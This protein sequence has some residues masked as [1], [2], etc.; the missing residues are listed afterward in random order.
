MSG[1]TNM[2]RRTFLK[3][4]VAI[5][6][7]LVI[8]ISI[9][10]TVK[11]GE[12]APEA[13][14]LPAAFIRIGSDNSVTIIINKSEMGQGVY[15]SLPM[16]VAEELEC[17][18]KMIRVE[19][20]PVAPVYNHTTFGVQATGGSTSIR[21]EW[22][23]LSKAGAA[24]RE[25]LVAAAAKRWR[26]E[27]SRCRAGNGAVTGPGGALLTYGE[28]AEEAARM[29]VPAKVTLK[30][31]RQYRVIGTPRHRLD[32]P[33]KVN[34]TAEFGIDVQV[35]GMLTAVVARSPVFGGRVAGLKADRA[36]SVPG[37][38]AVVQVPSGV[39]V[40]ATGFWPALKGRQLLEITWDEGKGAALSTPALRAE[41]AA[42]AARP[43]N[44]ARKDGD[45]KGVLTKATRRIDAEYEVPFLAHAPMEPLN[46]FVDLKADR[47]I[48]RVGTQ[49]Q[50]VDLHAAA[51]VAGLKPE[52]VELKTTYLGGGFG[53]RANPASDF[54]A[55]AVQVA[56][57][58]KKP[59][60]VI[61]T[62]GDD[63]KGGYYRPLWYDRISAG[64][65]AEG[66]LTAWGHTIVG[67]SII[68]GTPFE[69]AM[70][71][72]GVDVSS[73][74]GAS[75]L[76]YAV[77]NILVD[78]HTPKSMVPVLWWRSVGHSHTAFV[79]E[80]FM[81][82]VAHA[83]GKDPVE[84]RRS[85]LSGHPRHRG[86]LDLAA[87]KAGWGTPL[88]AG[89]A[90]G[91]AL[92][93]SFGSF[94]AQAAEVSV[95]GKGVVR[96]HRVVCAIDC[97]RIVNPD[98]IAAQMES[99]IAFG[100]SATLHGAITLKGGRVEQ[101]N[102]DTYPILRMNEMPKVEVHIVPSQDPPGGVGEP[103]VPPIAP[104]VANALFALTGIRVR[105]LP[106]TPDKVLQAMKKG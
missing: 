24:A 37:V 59:V 11:P 80:S 70:I 28:L 90:R 54:V 20:A 84:F 60:K 23:R 46:C 1:I 32:T 29:P 13:P 102:F 64:L 87:K 63:M 101:D 8:G 45:P 33:A 57:L 65:D 103:G 77:P 34:G 76:P 49:F 93:E 85:L 27:P 17:D 81:D 95:D 48:I 98:T 69:N 97:G 62:R 56:K 35:P 38:V 42:L 15:T 2:S 55:E 41:Y 79:V 12:A 105:S 86:V 67:Q 82:E 66:M 7:G 50:T 6:G 25:M 106:L 21:T 74:E 19:A 72:D 99:G 53:R 71:K 96:V 83:A 14:Y 26:V 88:P 91:I 58:A 9:P 44:V 3:G 30:E 5:G 10:L 78:L 39:A 89:R 68:A 16:L 51:A 22:E 92:H 75:D 73:V 104:A 52:Q 36:I 47:C 94:I 18:W 43:G 40:I 31:P 61:W 4:S 100:L